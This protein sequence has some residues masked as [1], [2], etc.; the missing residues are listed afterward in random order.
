MTAQEATRVAVLALAAA[1]STG[2]G[3]PPPIQLACPAGTTPRRDDQ[4]AARHHELY[5]ARANGTKHGPSRLFESGVRTEGSYANGEQ[6]GIWRS[7]YEN[8]RPFWR[9]RLVAGSNDGPAIEWDH[10]GTLMSKGEYRA[11]RREGQWTLTDLGVTG[12]GIYR[13]DAR[14]G[15]WSF[16]SEG[17][18]IAAGAY[19]HGDLEGPWVF[20]W[21]GGGLESRGT[22][23]RSEKQGR[24]RFFEP[25]GWL[26]VEVQCRAGQAH[27]EFVEFDKQGF[28]EM[29]GNFENDVG[30]VRALDGTG[31][32]GGLCGYRCWA[33]DHC[34]TEDDYR[35][36]DGQ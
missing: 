3:F 15:R 36:L 8:G 28:V 32:G 29:L 12:R 23:R 2:F 10:N 26:R 19:V 7:W 22:F 35:T 24:W 11:G 17:H 33:R 34:H 21:P 4:P 27:G 25:D 13:H 31:S 20:Y 16:S 18:R 30:G 14:E 1:G 5:C 9:R 6:V